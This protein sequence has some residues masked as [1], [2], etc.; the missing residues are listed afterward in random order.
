MRGAAEQRDKWAAA[1]AIALVAWAGAPAAAPAAGSSRAP[2]GGTLLADVTSEYSHIRV[3]QQGNV[4]SLLFV[5]D[6]GEE[7]VESMLNL[8]KPYELL[9]P[10]SRYMFASYLLKPSQRQVLIIGLGGGAMVHF[11]E[12]YAPDVRVDA[13]EI[14]PAV[15][16]I[17]EKHFDVR[18]HDNVRIITDD[19]LR[20]LE[21]TEIK[22]DVVY[23]D[24]FLKPS[25]DTDSAGVPLAMK[26]V[27]FYKRAAQKLAPEGLMVFNLNIHQRT[28]EDIQTI[29]G[30]FPQVYVFRV[31]EPNMVAVGS[32]VAAREKPATLRDRA[33]EID[34]RFRATFSFQEMVKSLLP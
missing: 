32:T 26:T 33:K 11:Y 31:P 28:K 1:L 3:R 20:Y 4:R 5:R 14:D 34:Q 25:P 30:A 29:R 24:A 10:Y 22:Y 12:H 21:K 27:E 7:V 8:R 19:G 6:G 17:A 18:A 23:M 9:S 16:K 15:V 13:V 2:R